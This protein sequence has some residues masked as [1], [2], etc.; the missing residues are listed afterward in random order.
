MNLRGIVVGGLGVLL[1]GCLNVPAADSLTP[2]DAPEA[3]QPVEL[4][5]GTPVGRLYRPGEVRAFAIEQAGQK[6]GHSWGRYVGE[7]T[8]ADGRRVHRFETKIALAVPGR[9]ELRAEGVLRLDDQGEVVS[10]YE[11]REGVESRFERVGDL[12]RI[13]DAGRVDELQYEPSTTPTAVM[14]HSAILH[15]EILLLSRPLYEGTTPL[16]LLSLSGGPPVDWEGTAQRRGGDILVRTSLGET[17]TLRDGRVKEIEVP[18]SRLRVIPDEARPW[19]TWSVELATAPHYTPGQTFEIRE[20]ELPGRTGEPALYGEVLLPR[21]RRLR[22]A[23]ALYVSASGQEDRHGI[24]G[25]P[26]VD[27]GSH[28]ITDA[29]AEAG[30]VVLRFDERGHGRSASGEGPVTFT[31]QV[32]DARR[33]FRT[34]LVQEE[35]DPDRVL[36]V[37]HGE[38]GWRALHIAVSQP[39]AGLA[40]LAVP[41]RPYR[42]VAE[43][44][45]TRILEALPPELRTEAAKA[46]RETLDAIADGGEVPPELADTLPWMREM[47]GQEPAK[48]LGRVRAPLFVAQGG[49]DFEVDPRADLEALLTAAPD[50]GRVAV[51]RYPSLDH[52]F[53]V[54][55]GRSEPAR[56]REPDRPVDRT[57]LQDLVSWAIS[58][59]ETAP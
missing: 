5:P 10:G 17:I 41:G 30:F 43:Y 25:H 49:K 51:H 9:G 24:A 12:L 8:L 45:F 42:Q 46:Q 44:Q 2:P 31:A 6:L 26:A 50:R 29:L 28:E 56:Y 58:V 21:E 1:A 20:V 36:V 55:P 53:K 32:E 35:V 33:A 47:M 4:R 13:D 27:L 48:L 22:G 11:R 34:L 14:A 39:L 37:G 3:S 59:V 57:F 19:P 23:A 16:R 54:E 40:L 15:E 18:A 52:R 38:G 7:E